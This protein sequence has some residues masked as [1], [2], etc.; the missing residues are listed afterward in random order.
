MSSACASAFEDFA[1]IYDTYDGPE[2]AVRATLTKCQSLAEWRAGMLTTDIVNE[3]FAT[4]AGDSLV[5]SE[6][7]IDCPLFKNYK[8]FPV[9]AEAI[10]IGLL[11][12]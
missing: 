4:P 1:K 7:Q 11:W 8:S 3:V 10:S 12:D 2:P 9:C 5:R 6:I